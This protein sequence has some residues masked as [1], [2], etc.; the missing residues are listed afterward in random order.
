MQPPHYSTHILMPGQPV[1][2]EEQQL[3]EGD[4]GRGAELLV[5]HNKDSQLPAVPMPEGPHQTHSPVVIQPNT[6]Y[7]SRI[8]N[9]MLLWLNGVAS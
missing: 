9:R 8:S 2:P 1:L 7:C 3:P 5:S 6:K 4:T